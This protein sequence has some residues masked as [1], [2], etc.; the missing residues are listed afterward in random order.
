MQTIYLGIPE[1][2]SI[3]Q[4][5]YDDKTGRVYE[6]VNKG[7]DYTIKNDVISDIRGIGFARLNYYDIDQEFCLGNNIGRVDKWLTNRLTHIKTPVYMVDES[8]NISSLRLFD[9]FYRLIC[10]SYILYAKL[11]EL[12]FDEWNDDYGNGRHFITKNEEL[13]HQIAITIRMVKEK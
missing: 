4:L 8:G 13:A 5:Y 9:N 2:R 11:D 1:T 3:R 7:Y 12:S 6:D 10:G